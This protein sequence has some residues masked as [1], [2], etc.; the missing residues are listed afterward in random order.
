MAAT[1]QNNL[2]GDGKIVPIR[3]RDE[4]KRSYLDYAMSVIVGRALPDLRDGLKPV[5]RRILYAMHELGL[6][7]EKPFKKCAKVV[8]EVLG[9]YHPH[10][11][12][13]VYDALVRLAQSFASRYPLVNGHGNFGSIE[14]DNAAAMRYTECKLTQIA[15]TMLED[16]EQDTVDFVPNYDGSEEEPDVLPTRLPVLL[17]NGSSGIAVG[18]ATNIPPFNL[19]EVVDGLVA[20]I[21]N[22]DLTPD[23]MMA[24]IKGPDFPTGGSIMGLQGIR[25]AFRGGRGSVIMRAQTHIEQIPGG[26]GRQERTA[27]VVT[28]IPYQVDLSNLTEKIAELVR[29]KKIE[30]ISDLR[31]ESDRDGL[32]LVIE[33]KRDANPDVVAR[34]LFKQTQLQTSFGVNMLALVNKQPR[35]LGIVDVLSEFVS[36]RETVVV[37]RTQFLLKKASARAHLL[38]GLMIALGDLDAVIQVIRA[39]KATDE[40]RQGLM[41]KYGLDEDQANAILEMQLRR[42]TSLEREKIAGEHEALMTQI[43]DYKAIL[44]DRNR[45]LTIIK[46]ELTELKEKYGDERR[47][48]IEAGDDSEFSIEE[49]TPNDAMGVFITRQGYIK[50]LSLDTFERQKRATRGKG[51]MKTREEDDVAHFFATHMHDEILF[52]TNKGVVYKRRVYDLPEGGRSA[53]GLAMINL[54]PIEQNEHVTAVVPMEKGHE[55]KFLVMLTAKG[56]IKKT[57]LEQF[58]NI[59]RNG[60]IA[61]GLEDG[62]T[63][64]WVMPCGDGDDVFIGTSGGMAIRFNSGKELRPLGRSARGVTAIRLRPQH[65]IVDFSVIP[66]EAENRGASLFLLTNDGFGKRMDLAEFRDQARGGIG[67]IGTKFKNEKS[68]VKSTCV[69]HDDEELMIVSAN[70]VVVRMRAGDIPKQSRMA[71]GVRIQAMDESDEVATVSKIVAELEE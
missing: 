9:K 55:A 43:A 29:D 42:L 12:T 60:L 61:I 1:K 34:N 56:W 19:S 65:T 33:L 70:G 22:P 36:F 32:R 28:E 24:Y 14:G 15:T 30:G 67:L 6:S 10:G 4:M 64:N 37:R 50:R 71:T 8:G 68:R 40:A 44:A 48:R 26:G 23:E 25:E 45:V 11:D 52:F 3:I 66:K 53:K 39:A 57:T 17:L 35:L 47:T 38:A 54:I 58:E 63:L 62:D 7:P 5:H 49:L 16:I 20:L 27:I 21:D 18:M 46:D 51:G 59:R 69:V 13:A 41:S 2:F 31:N